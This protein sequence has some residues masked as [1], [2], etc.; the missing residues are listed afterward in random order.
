M[1]KHTQIAYT[2]LSFSFPSCT[3]WSD[4]V[5]KLSMQQAAGLGCAS[6]RQSMMG[7]SRCCCTLPVPAQPKHGYK[8]LTVMAA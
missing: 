4:I 6:S 8:S 5:K 7:L 2:L 3:S 1:P